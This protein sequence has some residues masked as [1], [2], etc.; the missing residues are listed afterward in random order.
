M[1]PLR[2]VAGAKEAKAEII[3]YKVVCILVINGRLFLNAT[4]LIKKV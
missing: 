3:A 4:A 2:G 1:E